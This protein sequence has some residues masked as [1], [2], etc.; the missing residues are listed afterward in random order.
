M[1]LSKKKKKDESVIQ[2]K[3]GL[4]LFLTKKSGVVLKKNYFRKQRKKILKRGPN[5][6][7]IN[8]KLPQKKKRN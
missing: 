3:K 7:K 4:S 2:T 6:L 5:L 1:I 8:T